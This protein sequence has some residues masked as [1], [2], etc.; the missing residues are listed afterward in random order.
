MVNLWVVSHTL[1]VSRNAFSVLKTQGC[2]SRKREFSS[3]LTF[4]LSPKL[5]SPLIGNPLSPRHWFAVTG[6]QLKKQKL[7]WDVANL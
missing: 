2:R 5:R 7:N 4:K 1:Y 6:V 3:K